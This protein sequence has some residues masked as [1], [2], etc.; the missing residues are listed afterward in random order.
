MPHIVTSLVAEFALS[1]I[2][3]KLALW[4]LFLCLVAVL[5]SSIEP[6][7]SANGSTGSG[8]GIGAIVESA[9]ATHGSQVEAEAVAED[10]VKDEAL[11]DVIDETV[12]AEELLAT[13]PL[14]G[15]TEAVLASEP[16]DAAMDELPMTEPLDGATEEPAAELAETV[17][18]GCVTD[19]WLADGCWA[20]ASG[21]SG[22]ALS[23]S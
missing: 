11:A 2:S 16:L 7:Y 23:I 8:V 19:G 18:D 6:A 9:Q 21:L 14:D 5:L 4:N 20:V 10:V 17:G 12:A 13:E 3:M 1:L 15:A 22:P